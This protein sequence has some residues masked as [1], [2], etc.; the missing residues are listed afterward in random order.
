MPSTIRNWQFHDSDFFSGGVAQPGT[1]LVALYASFG[2]DIV[3]Q[4]IS[5]SLASGYYAMVT[6]LSPGAHTIIYGGSSTAFGPFDYQVT[7]SINVIAVPEPETYALM[8]AGMAVVAWAARRR[9]LRA[10]RAPA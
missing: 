10:A 4:D 5:P 7:A 2:I 9:G 8:L 3:G 6:G 1:A